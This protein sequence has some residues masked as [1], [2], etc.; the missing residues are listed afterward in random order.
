MSVKDSA[1]FA[2]TQGWG[3]FNFGHHAP[4][5]AAT[6]AAAP[7]EAC[8]GCHAASAHEDMVFAGFYRQL[9]ALPTAAR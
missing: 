8:A 4:P 9:E 6:A 3:F 2:D 5:Y 7:V 1:R